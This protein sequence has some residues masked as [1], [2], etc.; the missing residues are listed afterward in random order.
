MIIGN[1]LFSLNYIIHKKYR[2][3]RSFNQLICLGFCMA[4]SLQAMG[5]HRNWSVKPDSLPKVFL[6]G[7]YEK[8]FSQLQIDY[9]QQLIT[10]CKDDMYAA[11]GNW[12]DMLHE[13]ETYAS[14]INYDLKGIKIWLY[15]FWDKDGSIRHIAYFLKPQ[16]RNVKTEELTAFF[17]S[18]SNHYRNVLTSDH[19][20]SHYASASFPLMPQRANDK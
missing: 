13:M 14:Q 2:T 5:V 19:K 9:E 1:I 6:L 8:E 18:Y 10:V 16:S 20:F 15:V 11:Y 12:L 17:I 3:M 4:F 7:E